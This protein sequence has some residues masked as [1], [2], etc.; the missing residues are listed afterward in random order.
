M[1]FHIRNILPF[2]LV[3]TSK[4]NPL[5]LKYFQFSGRMSDLAIAYVVHIGVVFCPIFL[6]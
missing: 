4:V 1:F 5:H 3:A 6:L 2:V